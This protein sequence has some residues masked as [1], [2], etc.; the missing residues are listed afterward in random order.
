[1]YIIVAGAGDLGYYLAQILL[2]EEH[3]IVIIEKDEK[4]CEKI[5]GELDL[6]LIKGDAT[7]PKTLEKAGIKEADGRRARHT[8]HMDV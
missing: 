5:S 8:H 4:V 1:V 7:E 6:V 3:D 2:D